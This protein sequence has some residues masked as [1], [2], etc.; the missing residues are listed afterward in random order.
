MPQKDWYGQFIIFL[1]LLFLACSA[2][3]IAYDDIAL[4][5]P[6]SDPEATSALH[7]LTL[8]VDYPAADVLDAESWRPVVLLENLGAHEATIEITV[9]DGNGTELPGAFA[10]GR[11]VS[12]PAGGSATI[13]PAGVEGLPAGQYSFA[14]S[15][16]QPITGTVVL[17]ATAGDLQNSDL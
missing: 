17:Q 16:N 14:L 7:C 10:D 15:S 6:P 13:P 8:S 4:R 12:L 9:Y 5:H 1:I 2:L 11:P 3:G